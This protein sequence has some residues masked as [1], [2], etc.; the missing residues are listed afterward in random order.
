MKATTGGSFAHVQWFMPMYIMVDLFA[1]AA[2]N[3]RRTT[4][5]FILKFPTDELLGNLMDRGW[6]TK[7]HIEEDVVEC[8]CH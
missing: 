5:L 8:C 6:D 3:L 2:N 7:Y 1:N 4:T